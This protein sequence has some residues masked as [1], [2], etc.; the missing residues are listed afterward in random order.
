MNPHK[1]HELLIKWLDKNEPKRYM[2]KK[3]LSFIELDKL[4]SQV[5][6]EAQNKK[7]R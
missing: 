4:L 6:Q 5:C 1:V 7:Y 2:V 3:H